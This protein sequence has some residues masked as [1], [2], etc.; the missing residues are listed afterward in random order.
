[1]PLDARVEAEK[2]R[3]MY[4]GSQTQ[5]YLKV[6]LLGES[7]TGKTSLALT[8]P[9]P[10]HIDSFDPGGTKGLVDL[11]E[12]G[13]IIADTQYELEDPL[14][15]TA[16]TK[17]EW[18]FK[19]RL[20]GKYFESIG[21]YI[22]DSSTT[23]AD[24]IM[25]A[26]MAKG[27][28][29]GEA[30]RRNHD[31]VPQKTYIRNGIRQMQNLPCH[32]IVTGHLR[33]EYEERVVNKEVIR[34]LVG[35]KYMTTGQG[36]VLIPLLF[37]EHWITLTRDVPPTDTNRSGLEYCI[38]TSRWQY[39]EAGT[40][41]GRGRFEQFEKADFKA[42]LKKAGWADSARDKEPLFEGGAKKSK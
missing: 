6:L 12:R 17:W 40:R 14:A 31:Y 42:L 7:K 9:R 13:D 3:Q 23:W 18:N 24:A 41:I 11:I 4:K 38:L 33:P 21:T 26:I 36:D 5:G 10:V 25:N 27:G 16:I 19:Q 32:V 15:P 2:L 29:P 30:P 20:S 28:M 39:H 35:Y 22:L 37:D 34:R 1:M 8:C